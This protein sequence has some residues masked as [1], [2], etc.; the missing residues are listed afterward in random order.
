MDGQ[1]ALAENFGQS[2]AITTS[3]G[4]TNYNEIRIEMLL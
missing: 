1:V 2:L 4:G 3:E